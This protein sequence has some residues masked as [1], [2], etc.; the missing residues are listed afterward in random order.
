[1]T[2]RDIINFCLKFVGSYEDYPFDFLT[3]MPDSWTVMRHKGN[4][5]GFAHIYMAGDKSK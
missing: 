3:D 1:M 4:R 5:K 2:K